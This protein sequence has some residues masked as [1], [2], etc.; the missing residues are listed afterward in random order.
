MSVSAASCPFRMTHCSDRDVIA[1]TT[2]MVAKHRTF[3]TQL[4]SF[5][6]DPLSE[7]IPIAE[8]KRAK[9]VKE[10][11]DADSAIG[12]ISHINHLIP[13]LSSPTIAHPPFMMNGSITPL[14]LEI[15]RTDGQGGS[16]IYF[17]LN[18]I[19]SFHWRVS[20]VWRIVCMF[21]C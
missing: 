8:A 4:S 12:I 15:W 13:L 18:N 6:V 20:Y 14:S 17:F 16:K 7:Y 11:K 9:F 2:E 21:V 19:K 5:I 3:A 1:I 10:E